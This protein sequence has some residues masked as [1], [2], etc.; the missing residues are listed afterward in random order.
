MRLHADRPL[1]PRKLVRP[2]VFVLPSALSGYRDWRYAND[3]G[4]L[5]HNIAT[6][7]V[8]GIYLFIYATQ[9]TS[10]KKEGNS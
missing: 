9:S 10:C 4:A 3:R 2:H 8:L 7:L 6:P 1:A 5:G